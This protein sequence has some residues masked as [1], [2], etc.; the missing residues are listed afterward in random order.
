ML[1]A[2]SP[3]SESAK[4]LNFVSKV[5]TIHGLFASLIVCADMA[6]DFI[7]KVNK[8]NIVC[9]LLSCKTTGVLSVD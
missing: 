9:V 2:C 5:M 1:T 3:V 4:I 8:E 7:I 6:T